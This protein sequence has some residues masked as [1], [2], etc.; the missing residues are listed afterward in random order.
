MVTKLLKTF[1]IVPRKSVKL[2]PINTNIHNKLLFL[3]NM[4]N[5]LYIRN[6]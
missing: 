3:G 2:I 5:N 1:V 6:D 4:G